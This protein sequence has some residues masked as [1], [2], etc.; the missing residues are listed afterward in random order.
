[1]AVTAILLGVLAV[2]GA[3]EVWHVYVLAF[4]FGVGSAFDAPARQSFVSEM[5]GPDDLSNAVGLNSASFNE[6]RLNLTTIRDKRAIPATFPGIEIGGTGPRAADIIA[7]TEQ[8][9]A[10][11]SLDQDILEI[12]DDFTFLRGTH[13]FTVGTHNEFFEFGNVFLSSAFGHYYFN[14]LTL[15]PT[16]TASRA[17]T[18]G[19]TALSVSGALNIVPNSAGAF[20]L[21][22]NLG[23]ATTVTGATTVQDAGTATATLDTTASNFALNT[24]SLTIASGDT[25]NARG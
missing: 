6:A 25:V 14:N 4:A 2:T 9:S 18:F 1:M 11:N 23:A 22:T 21:T 8:F 13:T 12:T 15:S 7:G 19:T 17:Y 3:V 20:A 24:S 16:I 10:A 5:V